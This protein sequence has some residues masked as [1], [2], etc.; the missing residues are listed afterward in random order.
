MVISLKT[1]TKH[2]FVEKKK[3]EKSAKTVT[4]IRKF[5]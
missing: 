3:R 5:E 1:L 2:A 4:G